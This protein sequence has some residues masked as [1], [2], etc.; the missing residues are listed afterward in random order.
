M[1]ILISKAL[2][3]SVISHDEFVVINNLVKEY[4]EMEKVKNLKTWTVYLR[5]KS[6]YKAKLQYCLKCGKKQSKYTKAT[7][8]KNGR[9]ML[10]SKCAVCDS[11]KLKFIKE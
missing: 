4:D 7:R 10:L 6:I 5:F 2:I 3:N 9:I 11:K 8:T 1:S